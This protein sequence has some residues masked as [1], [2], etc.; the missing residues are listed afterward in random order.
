[1]DTSLSSGAMQNIRLRMHDS[2]DLGNERLFESQLPSQIPTAAASPAIKQAPEHHICK[3][4]FTLEIQVYER[5]EESMRLY[6]VAEFVGILSR[7]PEPSNFN[8]D[9]MDT[10]MEEELAARPPPSRVSSQL[11]SLA[12][13]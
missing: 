12:F 10:F 3:S 1:M 13:S 4:F 7:V 6:N 11:T 8:T 9:G 5:E 2:S